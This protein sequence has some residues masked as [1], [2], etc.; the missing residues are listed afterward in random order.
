MEEEELR[1]LREEVEEISR[2]TT[3]GRGDALTTAK[4]KFQK[5]EP[6]QFRKKRGD[7]H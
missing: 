3:A 4:K 2:T 7:V 6:N 1:R 5:D